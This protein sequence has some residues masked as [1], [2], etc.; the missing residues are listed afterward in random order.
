V[1]EQRAF[2]REGFFHGETVLVACA[3]YF[4]LHGTHFREEALAFF[5]RQALESNHTLS[6]VNIVPTASPV[7]A[8]HFAEHSLQILCR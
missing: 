3:G 7:K 5:W 2:L 8:R 1:N 4:H 6:L